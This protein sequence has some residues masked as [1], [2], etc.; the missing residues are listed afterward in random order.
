[1][2]GALKLFLLTIIA[3]I[4]VTFTVNNRESEILINLF[5]L[6]FEVGLST[7]QLIYLILII[8]VIIGSL[9]SSVK[10]IRY[11]SENRKYK[12]EIEALR[13]ELASKKVENNLY[14]ELT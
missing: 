10:N 7:W 2:I 8:G 4:M 13:H 1:M 12:K 5:P 14:K 6:P 9:F 11:R 3:I